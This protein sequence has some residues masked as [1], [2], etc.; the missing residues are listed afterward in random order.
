MDITNSTGCLLRSKVL[1][2]DFLFSVWWQLGGV[3]PHWGV[4]VGEARNCQS[5]IVSPPGQAV[6]ENGFQRQNSL[7]ELLYQ[8]LNSVLLHLIRGRFQ[9]KE[10]SRSGY[11]R[12][13]IFLYDFHTSCSSSNDSAYR[14]VNT[15]S[16]PVP[17]KFETFKSLLKVLIPYH[18]I[19]GWARGSLIRKPE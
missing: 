5:L 10:N 9:N 15:N 13:L 11:S 6:V 17:R 1:R 18:R 3:K 2:R 12:Y 19:P 14:G 4:G 16:N 7:I 8:E